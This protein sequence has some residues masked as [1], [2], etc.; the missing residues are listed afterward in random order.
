MSRMSAALLG[1]REVGFT[2]VSMS[3]SLVAVFIPFMF[4][5]GIVGRDIPRVHR[6]FVGV[7]PH[8]AGDL[9]DHHPDDVLVAALP[10]APSATHR[11]SARHSNA[12]SRGCAADTKRTLDWA[13]H[14]PRTM[15]L[16]LFATI[17]LNIYLY[18]VIPKGFF[19]QQDTGQLQ[20]GIRG[21]ASEFVSIDEAQAAAGRGHHPSGS[22]GEN[23][24]RAPSAAAASALRRR[25]RDR[26]CHHRAQAARR[27][28]HFRG[29]AS[30]RACGRRL[31]EVTGVA[32]FLQAV[33]D[34]GGGGG[35][36]ANSQYQ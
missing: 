11:G 6:H 4:A 18:V 14:H 20:G 9:P 3:L 30:S 33:Q 2:V 15:L 28:P 32:T 8:L 23:R 24:H 1:A 7:H 31:N 12:A 10:R 19:P 21:D 34:I 25:Q 35:R 22:R 36:S 13:L 27:T 26:Q 29:S 16:L 5:G 17:G